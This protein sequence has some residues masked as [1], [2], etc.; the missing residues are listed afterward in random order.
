MR[1]IAIVAGVYGAWLGMMATHEMG[2]V[3]HAWLSGGRVDRVVI[4]PL[5]FS[6]TDLAA[7]PHPQFVAWG[8]AT[9]GCA[10]PMIMLGALWPTVRI[11]RKIGLLFAGFCLIANGAY[12]GCGIFVDAG[13]AADLLRYGT[14]HWILVLFGAAAAAAGL[15]L[16]HIAGRRTLKVKT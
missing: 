9:W 2:H 16:W 6:R 14:P 5:G 11:A 1:W 3:I 15:Y 13:D 12:L 8:G 4:P 7:N 10:L